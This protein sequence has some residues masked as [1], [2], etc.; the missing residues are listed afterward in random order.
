MVTFGCQ[1][2]I[3]FFSIVT[4]SINFDHY[5]RCGGWLNFEL[6]KG[7]NFRDGPLNYLQDAEQRHAKTHTS[8]PIT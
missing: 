5:L 1:A 6:K 4:E 2:S 3:S 7:K 8:E